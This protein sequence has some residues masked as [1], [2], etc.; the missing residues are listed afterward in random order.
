MYFCY[1]ANRVTRSDLKDRN[2]YFAA[3]KHH[4]WVGFCIPY[5][6][7]VNADAHIRAD[8]ASPASLR[9]SYV[10]RLPDLIMSVMSKLGRRTLTYWL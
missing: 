8:P 4:F 10:K 1:I 2:D 9:G 6:I 3:P 5:L 7:P